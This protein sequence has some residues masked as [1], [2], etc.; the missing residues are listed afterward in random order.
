MN[1]LRLFKQRSNINHQ[2]RMCQIVNKDYGK[3][4]CYFGVFMYCSIVISTISYIGYIKMYP[5]KTKIVENE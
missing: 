1:T 4:E 3:N 2:I 5:P